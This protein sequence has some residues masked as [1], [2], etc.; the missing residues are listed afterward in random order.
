MYAD[1][2]LDESPLIAVGR[3]LVFRALRQPLQ[4]L[5]I[6]LLTTTAFI[7]WRA[8]RTPRYRATLYY[9]VIESGI[10]DLKNAPRPV[11]AIREY[12]TKVAL[13]REKIQEIMAR[14]NVSMTYWARDPAGASEAFREDVRIDVTRNYFL[15]DRTDGDEPRSAQVSISLYGVDPVRTR[16]ILHEIGQ[17]FVATQT[18][19]RAA[20]LA[21]AR[22]NLETQLALARN[23]RQALVER[24]DH[25]LLNASRAT[26]HAAIA[27]R[28]EIASRQ[29]ELKSALDKV[30]A[31][32]RRA[33]S[34]A[35]N[36]A[37]EHEQLGLDFEPF[38][39]AVVAVTA[40]LGFLQIVGLAFLVFV[41]SLLLT[42]PVVGAF[43][44]RVY[45]PEDLQKRGL[46]C[47]GGLPRF[48]TDD[49]GSYD[50]R[51]RAKHV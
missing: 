34:V 3:Q 35:F 11:R 23:E 47:F 4:V 45:T 16:D 6:A 50:A 30:I 1:R 46:A 49:A 8:T 12:I 14:H 38:D 32:E 2:E 33:A 40:R 20:R 13:S 15:Y 42:V 41:I 36:T 18:A 44:D 5:G 51:I 7:A 22:E 17:A 43:D 39:E 21:Q 27:I 9:T 28:A 29:L 10:T 48:D 26:P 25:L 31:L 24:I 19:H 37:A